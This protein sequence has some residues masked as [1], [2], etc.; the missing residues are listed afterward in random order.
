MCVCVCVKVGRQ[1]ESENEEELKDKIDFMNEREPSP[2][3]G[4]CHKLTRALY[5]WSS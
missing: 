3:L 2:L 5:S 1:Y 4:E